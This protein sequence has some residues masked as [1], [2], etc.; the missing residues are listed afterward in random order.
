MPA[1]S[2]RSSP[3]PRGGL[4]GIFVTKDFG[5]NWT[6]VHIPTVP[7]PTID[8]FTHQPGDSRPTTSASRTIR[9]SAGRR[10]ESPGQL[11]QAIAVDPTNPS[12][13]YVGGD[14]GRQRDRIDPHRPDHIWD[15]HNL[16]A[17]PNSSPTTADALS[18]NSTGRPTMR[19]ILIRTRWS[20]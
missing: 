17:T 18:L 16:V 9:S 12:V 7:T 2:T 10:P 6:M 15:A 20:P 5:Q 3:T 14:S 8:G 1:G 19:P 4:Y 13:I 11:Q